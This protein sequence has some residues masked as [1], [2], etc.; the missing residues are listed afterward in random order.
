LLNWDEVREMDRNGISFGAHTVTHAFLPGMPQEAAKEEI[1]KSKEIVEAEV[2]KPVRHF[3]IP[4]GKPEDFTEEL[5][6]FCQ[7][8]GFD[9]IVTTE[10]GRLDS[11]VDRFSLKRALPPPPLYYFACEIARQLF[12]GK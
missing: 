7:G 2:G 5:R 3:A 6:L 8:I 10:P 9:T 4:N 1:R 11:E 12:L